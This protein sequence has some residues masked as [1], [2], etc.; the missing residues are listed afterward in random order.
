L[1]FRDRLEAGGQRTEGKGE[2]TSGITCPAPRR[3]RK[4]LS[5]TRKIA[6]PGQ[7]GGQRQERKKKREGECTPAAP[8]EIKGARRCTVKD[9]K[10]RREL[11]KKVF[12]G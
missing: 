3:S 4:N 12:E 1:N 5:H 11:L 2:K 6:V 10:A 9:A 8:R 7:G